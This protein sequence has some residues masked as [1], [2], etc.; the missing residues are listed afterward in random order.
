MNW[1]LSEEPEFCNLLELVTSLVRNTLELFPF[2]PST[3]FSCDWVTP[4][5]RLRTI[6][7]IQE[8]AC[9]SVIY[10]VDIAVVKVFS[11]FI[12]IHYTSSC[13]SIST[14][15]SQG[16]YSLVMTCLLL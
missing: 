6:K 4:S 3:A 7:D 14:V 12:L 13:Q 10:M 11:G 1:T 9:N 8:L 5:M 16:L 2:L 15:A